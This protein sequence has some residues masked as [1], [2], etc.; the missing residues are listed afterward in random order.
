MT[1]AL[2]FARLGHYGVAAALGYFFGSIAVPAFATLAGGSSSTSLSRLIA[3][4]QRETLARLR[5]PG[6][7]LPLY[8][9]SGHPQL[10]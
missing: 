5:E 8:S 6:Q 10:P 3:T 4:P 2:S 7:H 1:R 9:R